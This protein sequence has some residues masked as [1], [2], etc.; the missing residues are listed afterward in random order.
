MKT[1]T[2]FL[3]VTL[4]LVWASTAA[5]QTC[6]TNQF[7]HEKDDIFY[8]S[9]RDRIA[10]G[11]VVSGR[12]CVS[13]VPYLSPRESQQGKGCPRGYGY[14][15]AGILYPSPRKRLLG[16][17]TKEEERFCVAI[18]KPSSGALGASRP[19]LS[20]QQL[21]DAILNG[22]ELNKTTT[23][24][25]QACKQSC[26]TLAL[27][28]AWSW[29]PNNKTCSLKREA[30]ELAFSSNAVSGWTS[31]YEKLNHGG[32]GI[33]SYY[34]EEQSSISKHSRLFA[35]KYQQQGVPRFATVLKEWKTVQDM[36]DCA[37][38]CLESSSVVCS[39]FTYEQPTKSCKIY[40]PGASFFDTEVKATSWVGIRRRANAPNPPTRSSKPS[41]SSSGDKA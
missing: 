9:P 15:R 19:A 23:P 30:G 26:S 17:S 6:P 21:S 20:M 32:M 5:A 35:T 41:H 11:K 31:M 14:E 13:I 2:I 27:C 18:V 34:K 16:H 28:A 4:S 1:S 33:G 25:A 29:T 39:A 37:R 3:L 22:A 40:N 36:D 8:P 7:K 38:R 12:T 24:T 10:K